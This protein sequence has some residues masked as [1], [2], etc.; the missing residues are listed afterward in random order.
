MFQLSFHVIPA[1]AGTHLSIA[2]E[3]EPWVPACAGMTW[4][5]GVE[6]TTILVVTN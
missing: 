6:I 5:A 3:A 2:R 1:Q 4:A